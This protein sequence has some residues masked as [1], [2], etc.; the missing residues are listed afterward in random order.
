M[1]SLSEWIIR[2]QRKK[3]KNERSISQGNR[4][5]GAEDNEGKAT[6]DDSSESTEGVFFFPEP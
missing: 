2:N 3:N 4:E 6:G 5:I 1:L